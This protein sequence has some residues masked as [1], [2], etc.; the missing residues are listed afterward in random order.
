MLKLGPPDLHVT[1]HRD[2]SEK[3]R[4]LLSGF[5][6]TSVD[7]LSSLQW[8]NPRGMLPSVLFLSVLSLGNRVWNLRLLSNTFSKW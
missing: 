8:C 2:V 4:T 3:M 5:K 6:I 7:L 1:L